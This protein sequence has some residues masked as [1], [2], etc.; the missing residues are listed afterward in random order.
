MSDTFKCGDRVR[1]K[2]GG[3]VMAV[4]GVSPDSNGRPTVWCAWFD[5][6]HVHKTAG[7]ESAELEGVEIAYLGAPP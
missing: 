5:E 3:P 1:L 2:Q 7:Y 4:T 6:N